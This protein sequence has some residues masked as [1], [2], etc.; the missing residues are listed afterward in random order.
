MEGEFQYV[1]KQARFNARFY[2]NKYPDVKEAGVDPLEHYNDHGQYEGRMPNKYFDPKR[3]M[4]IY[5]DLAQNGI[6]FERGGKTPW[7]HYTEEG[8]KEHRRLRPQHKC[9]VFNHEFYL[10]KYPDIAA[11]GVDPTTHYNDIGQYEGRMPN[12]YF[13]PKKYLAANPDLA[14]NGISFEQGGK[15]PWMHY[16]EF[17]VKEKRRLRP[18]PAAH[19]FEPQFYLRTYPDVAAAGVDPTEHY[20][21]H[22]QYE[23]RSANWWFDPN[24]Y[25]A[26]NPDL[27]ENGISFERGGKTP[28]MHFTEL[29]HKEN[30]RLTPKIKYFGGE[31]SESESD[32][33]E[34]V[35][36]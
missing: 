8:I 20:N 18:Y 4:A 14:A 29:G 28:W 30:R 26:A 35:V 6:S 17:G 15:T 7:M 33:E 32:D 13:D 3:Y 16:L 10:E 9:D 27:A 19:I 21:E 23:G 22:G 34:E 24:K 1:P 31:D 12:K 2:L 25:L 36:E 11:A 5:P